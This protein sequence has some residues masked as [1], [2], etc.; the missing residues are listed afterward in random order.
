MSQLSTLPAEIMSTEEVT[1][2]CNFVGLR[3]LSVHNFQSCLFGLDERHKV[4]KPNLGLLAQT[5]V[6]HVRIDG[7]EFN[8][9][10]LI[11]SAF[12]IQGFHQASNGV[13]W[14]AIR[15]QVGNSEQACCWRKRHYMPVV[16]PLHGREESFQSLRR[17]TY[18]RFSILQVLLYPKV[19]HHVDVHD[20]LD[21]ICG[22]F[23]ERVSGHDS[24]IVDQNGYVS[25]LVSHFFGDSQYVVSTWNVASASGRFI[26]EFV[27][28]NFTHTKKCALGYPSWAISLTVWLPFFSLMSQM[29]T[30]APSEAYRRASSL[31]I[32]W[33]APV[34]F[35][36]HGKNLFGV[37]EQILT[38]T[39][40]PLTDLGCFRIAKRPILKIKAYNI[41]IISTI[42]SAVVWVTCTSSVPI[43]CWAW[44]LGQIFAVYK[45]KRH[46]KIE[47]LTV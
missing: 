13:F 46:N 7:S 15:H 37:F 34:T 22:V 21:F 38:K 2:N 39:M 19:R 6:H 18:N 23:Q 3:S 20:S 33:P 31:P 12:L 24:S 1:R 42:T 29:T 26:G 41:W 5:S 16:V 28:K 25:Y 9:I 44:F 43:S 17:I 32:P 35:N 36:L 40:S 27:L 8:V 45:K 14:T 47:I 10:L 30:V 4:L 11:S